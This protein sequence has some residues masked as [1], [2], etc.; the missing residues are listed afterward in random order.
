MVTDGF[1]RPKN[2][3]RQTQGGG[4]GGGDEWQ[5]QGGG[6]HRHL[7]LRPLL[8]LP[9]PSILTLQS[10]GLNR[11]LVLNN[12]FAK[13]TIT[14]WVWIYSEMYTK[15]FLY[16]TYITPKLILNLCQ[17]RMS[18]C[19]GRNI[20]IY[21]AICKSQEIYTFTTQAIRVKFIQC[22]NLRCLAGFSGC[23]R[24]QFQLHPV[25]KV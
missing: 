25:R 16:Y 19:L 17:E 22:L 23:D 8:P 21:Q 6:R 24:D 10:M 1:K 18:L 5:G 14:P 2:S 4:G 11:K 15:L 13:S 3:E 7:H 20:H 9:N 12:S